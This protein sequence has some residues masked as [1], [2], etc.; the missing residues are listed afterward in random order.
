MKTLFLSLV[1]AATFLLLPVVHSKEYATMQNC[2]NDNTTVLSQKQK[3]AG[4]GCFYASN[5]KIFF[6]EK[7]HFCEKLVSL[8]LHRWQDV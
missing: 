8:S 5:K 6:L 2:L 3:N 1:S 4:T 7:T